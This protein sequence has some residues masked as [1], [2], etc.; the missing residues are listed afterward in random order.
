M[1]SLDTVRVLLDAGAD[2][3]QAK[4]DGDTPLIVAGRFFYSQEH[5]GFSVFIVRL[6]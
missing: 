6:C 5:F 4:D 1:G 2:V 3:N